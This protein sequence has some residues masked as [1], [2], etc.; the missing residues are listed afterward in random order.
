MKRI[1]IVCLLGMGLLLPST[2]ITANNFFIN[3]IIDVLLEG[4]WV[5]ITSDA[6]TGTLTNVIIY[7]SQEQKVLAEALS[8][9][10]DGVDVGG[11]P[12]GSYKV[13]VYTTL[14][15]YTEWINL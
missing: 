8:G 9:Y 11:L 1:L 2:T 6:G 5:E 10:T 7:N 12:G 14:T 3:R 15:S 13:R 4:D